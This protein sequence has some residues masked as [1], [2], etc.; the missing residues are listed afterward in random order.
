MKLV[1]VEI[2]DKLFSSTS[3]LVIVMGWGMPLGKRVQKDL[4]LSSVYLLAVKGGRDT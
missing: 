4:L 3:Y 2:E 1:L